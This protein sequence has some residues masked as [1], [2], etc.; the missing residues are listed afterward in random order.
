MSTQ[1]ARDQ[2]STE[3]DTGRPHAFGA[4]DVAQMDVPPEPPGESH[5]TLVAVAAVSCVRKT[6]GTHRDAAR[7]L[8]LSPSGEHAIER[9]VP[10]AS[11][12]QPGKVPAA[13]HVAEGYS[14]VGTPSESVVG[15]HA[16][17]IRAHREQWLEGRQA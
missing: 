4:E 13:M 7:V 3:V 2:D 11:A 14:R 10:R 5:L 12:G 6:D 15:E 1:H 17:A 9:I 8:Y 16:A